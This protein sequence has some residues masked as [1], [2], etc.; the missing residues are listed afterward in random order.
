MRIRPATSGDL[1]GVRAC[2]RAAYEPHAVRL[3]RPPAPMLADYATLIRDGKV[4][5]ADDRRVLGLIVLYPRGDH[6]HVENVAVHPD[7][8][9]RGLG[10]ALLAEAEKTARRLRLPAVELY[11]NEAMVEN[12]AYYRRLGFFEVRRGEENGFRRVWFR[13]P[14]AV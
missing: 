5:V 8:R 12:V 14:V 13:K 7:L 1:D 4:L 9:G 2:V 11:T 6:V 3:G 10:S